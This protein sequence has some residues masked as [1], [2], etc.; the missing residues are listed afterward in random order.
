MHRTVTHRILKA[1]REDLARLD[2]VLEMC[3]QLYNAALQERRDAWLKQKVSIT[4][5]EQYKELTGLR[6]DE[7]EWAALDVEMVRSTILKRVDEAFKAFFRRVKSGKKPGYPRFKGKGRFDTLVFTDRGW[8]LKG[9]KLILRGIGWLRVRGKNCEGKPI[10]LRLVRK[11]DRWYAQVLL[12]IGAKPEVK[13]STNGVGIDVGLK[14]FATLSNGEQIAHPKF[15]KKSLEKLEKANQRLGRR[16]RG[17]NRRKEAKRLLA[18]THL[19]IANQRKDFIHKATRQLVNSYDGF[20]V[21][22]LKVQEMVQG[23]RFL[24]RGIMDSAWSL[25]FATLAYKAEEAGAPVVKVNP[26]GTTQ[27]CSQCGT[28]VRKGLRDRWHSCSAC[29][30]EMDRDENAAKNILRGAVGAGGFAP[31]SLVEKS[32]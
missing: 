21:E 1:R 7:E 24:R 30:L 18:R 23:P 13:P 20:A 15:L 6:H 2:E 29:G 12:D 9:N 16:K 10:G 17:S 31:Q 14:T 26:K 5:F 28:I 19:K 27:R 25:F 11:A 32:A 3:R 4:L 8:K 22:D